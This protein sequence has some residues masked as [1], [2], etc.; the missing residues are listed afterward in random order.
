MAL[1]ASP[2]LIRREMPLQLLRGS[3]IAM[4]T[5]AAQSNLAQASPLYP[6]KS[7]RPS[8]LQPLTV[9]LLLTCTRSAMVLRFPVD[10]QPVALFSFRGIKGGVL[11]L[12]S[13]PCFCA[14]WKRP[15]GALSPG[16]PG[17]G[18][19]HPC[20]SDPLV[21]PRPIRQAQRI[22]QRPRIRQGCRSSRALDSSG[23]LVCLGPLSETCS[24]RTAAGQGAVPSS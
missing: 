18:I 17:Q 13:L 14:D 4:N 20:Q 15:G 22:M 12:L 24:R 6:R 8:P 7:Q 9:F 3:E 23:A 1:E 11:P 19:D 2:L 21:S 10:A 5:C 16:F